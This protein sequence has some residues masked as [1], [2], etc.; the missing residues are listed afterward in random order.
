MAAEHGRRQRGG[1]RD[2][3]GEDPPFEADDERAVIRGACQSGQSGRLDQA[4]YDA[5]HRF[6]ATPG[7]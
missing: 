3:R 2:R 5:A 6:L 7:W 4:T 1:G